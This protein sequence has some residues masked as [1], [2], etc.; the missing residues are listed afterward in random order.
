MTIIVVNK[1]KHVP[2]PE[3][4][5]YI[6]R[7]S[8]LGNPWPITPTDSRDAVIDRY[9]RWLDV[10]I[11]EANPAVLNALVGIQEVEEEYGHISLVCFCKPQRCHGDVIKAAIAKVKLSKP[12]G[13]KS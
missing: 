1:Y 8:A 11:A 5:C 3:T 10:Q 4:D 12:L 13:N 9:E 6:G 2:N 7:G